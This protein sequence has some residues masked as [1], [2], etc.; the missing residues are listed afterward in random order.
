MK[1]VWYFL[2]K[3]MHSVVCFITPSSAATISTTISVHFVPRSRIRSNAAWPAQKTS[4]TQNQTLGSIFWNIVHAK[5]DAQRCSR[6]QIEI[7][8]LISQILNSFCIFGACLSVIEECYIKNCKAKIR[9][10]HFGQVRGWSNKKV[11][12]STFVL[13]VPKLN[14]THLECQWK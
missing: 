6:A 13:T 4:V 10:S 5:Q 12:S 9:C 8:Q 1:A 14:P 11:P 2:M 3:S 7:R